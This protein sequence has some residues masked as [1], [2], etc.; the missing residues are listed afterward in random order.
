VII[1][2]ERERRLRF[3]SG[4]PWLDLVATVGYAHTPTPLERLS[5][6]GRLRE[7]LATEG[8]LPPAELTESDL[9]LARIVR[10][11]LRALAEAAVHSEPLPLGAVA[12]LNEVL[13]EDRPIVIRV[14]RSGALTVSR[15][16][17]VWEAFGRVARQAVEDLTG[18]VAATL[19]SCGDDDCSMVFID[20]TGRRRWCSAET[21]GVRNR[22]RAHRERQR[23]M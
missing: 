4:A 3:D 15:P 21:C 14:N 19:R 6:L 1:D 9:D 2:D 23:S 12:R 10:E 20:S 22:V 5:D 18:P 7:W 13:A 8:L 17:S 16:A 11:I